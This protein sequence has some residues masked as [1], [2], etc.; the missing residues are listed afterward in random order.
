MKAGRISW[1][2]GAG[3]AAALVLAA[4]VPAG[5]TTLIRQSLDHLVQGSEQVVL[6]E[7]VDVAS[8]WN[9]DHS[10]ILTDVTVEVQ[11]VL[12]G[13]PMLKQQT[14]TLMGGTVGDLSTLIIGGAELVPGEFYVLFLGESDLPGAK[15]AMT[16]REHC[17]GVF[18]VRTL[19]GGGLTAVSQAN[20][21]P[22]VPD[23][24]GYID[25]P[26][27]IDGFPLSAMIQSIQQ[28]AGSNAGAEVR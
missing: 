4:A 19:P 8:Y 25:A 1:V 17:Q 11:E 12:K 28:I 24:L 15:S 3:L 10:F 27:G 23:R 2:L 20:R 7:V 5:A 21:H 14:V 22:L 16:V 26:G 13:G 9:D 18:E 6:G